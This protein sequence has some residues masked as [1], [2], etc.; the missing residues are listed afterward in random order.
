[1]DLPVNLC[2]ST[3][4]LPDV[5]QVVTCDGCGRSCSRLM[6]LQCQRKGPPEVEPETGPAIKRPP[7][8]WQIG[9]RIANVLGVLS[10][11]P[12]C[13]CDDERTKLNAMSPD[14]VRAKV[15]EIAQRMFDRADQLTGVSGWLAWMGAKRFPLMAKAALKMLVRDACN[16]AER[17]ALRAQEAAP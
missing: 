9:D 7:G 8:G 14:Q 10:T 6:R 17:D 12:G 2:R 1:M 15:D 13:G 5:G 11:Q 4:P 16:G 3:Q